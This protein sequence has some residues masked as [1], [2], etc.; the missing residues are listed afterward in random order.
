MNSIKASNIEISTVLNTKI[1]AENI[2][3][4][5]TLKGDR[6]DLRSD[7]KEKSSSLCKK[8]KS[9][10]GNQSEDANCAGGSSKQNSSQ[11]KTSTST[12]KSSFSNHKSSKKNK[13]FKEVVEKYKDVINNPKC[14]VNKSKDVSKPKDIV[15]KSKD[16][17]NKSIDIVEKSKHNVNKSKDIVDKSNEKSFLLKNSNSNCSSHKS[18][19]TNTK[20]AKC[21]LEKKKKSSGI[22][23]EPKLLNGNRS[24]DENNSG[25]SSK[26]KTTIHK[27]KNSLS[28]KTKSFS[29]NHKTSRRY[30]NSTDVVDRSKNNSLSKNS[31]SCIAIVEK[32]KNISLSKNSNSTAITDKNKNKSSLNTRCASVAEKSKDK[33]LSK[34]SSCSSY[35]SNHTDTKRLKLSPVE[36]NKLPTNKVSDEERKPEEPEKSEWNDFRNSIHSNNNIDVIM[37]D[38]ASTLSNQILHKEIKNN[39]AKVLNNNKLLNAFKGFSEEDTVPCKNYQLL[40]NVIKTSEVQMSNLDKID[41]GFKGFTSVETN[42][43]KHRDNVYAELIKMKESKTSTGFIGFS[44]EDTVKSI[45]H[46]YVVK[47]LQLSKKRNNVDNHQQNVKCGGNGLQNGNPFNEVMAAHLYKSN[48]DNDA[49]S[50]ENFS[51][52]FN[53]TKKNS[54][55]VNNNN[56][57]HDNWVIKQE[58]K[59]KLVPLKVKLERL[60]I[61]GCNNA[62]YVSRSP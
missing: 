15:D 6:K 47:L 35:K 19:R 50:K 59:Y 4:D 24:D 2:A 48:N 25:G 13:S 43:C 20:E 21:S 40:K 60:M 38:C 17:V 12:S 7:K 52:P 33:S 30:N 27:N 26:H 8:S 62:N 18:Y 16:I 37:K 3:C 51:K 46:E 49:K 55:T 36:K 23:K 10:K 56:H 29:S 54:P 44:K 53:D 5:K 11:H 1:D 22:C 39:G 61:Y 42:P 9:L 31:T 28:D 14:V 32:S 41:N 45:G 34:D 58:I 57:N